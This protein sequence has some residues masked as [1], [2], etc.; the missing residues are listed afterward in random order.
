[1]NIVN[2]MVREWS[3]EDD[4]LLFGQR[5]DFLEKVGLYSLKSTKFNHHIL[6]SNWS[7]AVHRGLSMV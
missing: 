6:G 2:R 1:M 4:S 7:E 3:E 5:T